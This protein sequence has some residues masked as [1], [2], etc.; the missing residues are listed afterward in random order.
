MG[1]AAETAVGSAPARL[2]QSGGGRADHPTDRPS[3]PLL[4]AVKGGGLV[5]RRRTA[6]VSGI[7][8]WFVGGR[9]NRP[10]DR[11]VGSGFGQFW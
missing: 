8:G 7:L 4:W 1:I 6:N 5:D 10:A 9:E 2:G 3:A 11:L